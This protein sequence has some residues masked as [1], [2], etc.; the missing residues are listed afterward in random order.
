MKEGFAFGA[1]LIVVGLALQ[2]SVGPIHWS[3][4]AFPLNGLDGLSLLASHKFV[5]V[6]H[7]ILPFEE[8]LSEHVVVRHVA[9][10]ARSVSGVC[11]VHPRSVVG[12]HNVT[13]HT[14]R[15]IIP[16]IGVKSEQIQEKSS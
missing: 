16:Q 1:G 13:V 12:S 10:I 5:N 11:P 7:T 9:I 4:F 8:I 2:F 15:R 3:D 14:S 6:I